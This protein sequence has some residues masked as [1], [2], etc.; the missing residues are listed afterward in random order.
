MRLTVWHLTREHFEY[1]ECDAFVVIAD[2]SL[3]ARELAALDAGAEGPDVWLRSMDVAPIGDARDE[4]S[5]GVVV[6]SFN[7]G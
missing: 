4:L 1:D 7:A 3:R 2:T 5:E 6:R